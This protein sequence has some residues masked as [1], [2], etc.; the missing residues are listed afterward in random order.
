[1][2]PSGLIFLLQISDFVPDLAHMYFQEEL[3]V[4][5]SLVQASVLLCIGLQ[6]KNFPYVEVCF[7][8]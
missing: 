6:N 5:L 4:N 7:L 1:M 2:T 3:P 8:T